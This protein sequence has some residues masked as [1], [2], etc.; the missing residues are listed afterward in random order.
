MEK[1]PKPT[2]DYFELLLFIVGWLG[3]FLFLVALIFAQHIGI[4]TALK[5]SLGYWLFI[6]IVFL[7]IILLNLLYILIKKS[8]RLLNKNRSNISENDNSLDF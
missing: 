2:W 1:S 4:F 3:L 6:I 5:V 7:S 8:L